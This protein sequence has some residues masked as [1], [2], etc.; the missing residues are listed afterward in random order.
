MT[1][2]R[3]TQIERFWG[4]V[5][6]ANTPVI[7]SGVVC[8]TVDGPVRHNKGGTG[9]ILKYDLGWFRKY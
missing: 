8:M 4:V 3:E 1:I 6:N 7:T 2:E 9:V 5:V